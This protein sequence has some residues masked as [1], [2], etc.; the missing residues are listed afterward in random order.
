LG[1]IKCHRA[2]T[3]WPFS[4]DARR[5]SLQN[6]TTCVRRWSD[7]LHTTPLPIVTR[8]FFTFSRDNGKILSPSTLCHFRQNLKAYLSTRPYHTHGETKQIAFPS[9]VP[10]VKLISLLMSQPYC[11][12]SDFMITY[13]IPNKHY[14]I[15]N[16]QIANK[17]WQVVMDRRCMYQPKG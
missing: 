5:M 2:K 13:G 7:H 14:T 9:L 16:H 1:H 12:V 4:E 15:Y 17:K 3:Y 6:R 8:D 10:V 11:V